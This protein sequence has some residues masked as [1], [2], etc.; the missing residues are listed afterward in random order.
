MRP[1][2]IRIEH[3]REPLGIDTE[4]PVVS[5]NIR[6]GEDRSLWKQA[7]Y[8]ITVSG[9]LGTAWDSGY[10][11]SSEMH[12][13][14][15]ADFRPKERAEVRVSVYDEQGNE[16]TGRTT[17]EMGIGRED[18]T[19]EWI[20]PEQETPAS[21]GM[22]PASCLRK[23]FYLTS[24]EICAGARLYATAH[25]T[26]RILING[27]CVEGF[28]LAPGTSEY[29]RL[30]Q[31]QTYDV[32]EYL[33][34]GENEIRAELGNGWWRGTVTFDGIRNSFGDDVA[35]LAQLECGG[36]PVCV[37]D[38]SWEASQE[39]PLRDT[40]LMQG[41]VYDARREDIP[42]ESWHMVRT[43]GY[44][45]GNLAAP[46]C[47]GVREHQTFSPVLLHT[48][49]GE[50]VLDFGQNIAGYIG[51]DLQAHEGEKY[52][53][54]HGETLDLEGN[55]T[56]ENFQSL[57]F[58]CG[59]RVEYICRE[60]RNTYK[61]SH[62]FMGFRYVKVEGMEKI[63]PEDF[64][65]YALYTDLE[66]TAAFS[67]GHPLVDRLV[68]N[69]VWSLRSNLID[70]PTDCP[71]REK[72]GFSGDLVT[73]IHTF[74]YL[75][76]TYPMIQKYIRNQAVSQY[77]DGCVK[78]IVADP[79]ERGAMDGAGG[80]CDSF[81]ILPDRN[82]KWYH[83]DFLFEK[84]YENIKKWAD[85]LIRRAASSTKAE[86]L[87]NP[88]HDCLDDVGT[89]W[90][91]W[92]EPDFDFERYMANIRENGEPEVGTAY[93]SYA[94]LL[95]SRYARKSGRMEDAEYYGKKADRARLA[96]RYQ[97][98]DH[99][100][101]RSE[102]MCRYIRPIVLE[103]LGEQ[104]K[105]EA[106]AELNRLAEKNGYRLNTGFLTTH[107]LC[108]TLSDYGYTDTAYRLLL[109]EGQPGWLDPVKHGMTTIPE[110][111][112][113]FQPDGARKDSFNHYSY[114]AVTGWLFDTAAGIRLED[115]KLLIKPCPYPELKRLSAECVTPVGRVKSSWEYCEGGVKFRFGIPGNVQ[116][117]T[118]LPSGRKELLTAGE[119]EFFEESK[120][121]P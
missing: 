93:L 115:G 62:T 11:E 119:Y 8:R 9:H 98:T 41:E 34:E 87:D 83:D 92:L 89:H 25:G 2:R 116:A 18:W 14:I 24:D 65:A 39:G 45:Y 100:R 13:R 78:Q 21:D 113:A 42:E 46:D 1:E 90:G 96:Y 58:R 12:H 27:R 68:R 102:R 97:F 37:T 118:V 6:T 99:G 95:V 47:P 114:G 52:I 111:W 85:F 107:E 10:V 15:D 22:R 7:G 49:N 61:A 71:T 59:Q 19:A 117:E 5:W 56:I 16:G 112:R 101:I 43:A 36:V 73:Y 50:S 104:E 109:Q 88:Y 64:T 55:L 17:F 33:Q 79:R 82:A 86:H 75:M 53:F 66:E 105:K 76:D 26:Y 108:R 48:P 106:A 30:L 44:G 23:K 63:R 91:E 54:T 40:D 94:C 29:H 69:A 60:G 20:D 84:Y 81:E 67:C 70:I 74:Q 31:Y 32:T 110:N 28:V 3:M 103:L 38:D 51:F 77:E 121:T 72:S 4:H 35:L 120:P 57:N 80:W